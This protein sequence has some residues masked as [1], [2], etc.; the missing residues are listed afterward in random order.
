MYFLLIL[1]SSTLSKLALI[2]KTLDDHRNIKQWEYDELYVEVERLIP[3]FKKYVFIA[4]QR[5]HDSDPAFS[6]FI[7]R[8]QIIL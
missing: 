1:L 3:E 4:E 7:L 6:N 5:T 8:I 2:C